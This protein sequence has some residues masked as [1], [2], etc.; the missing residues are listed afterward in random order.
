MKRALLV[1][2]VMWCSVLAPAQTAVPESRGPA[3]IARVGKDFVTEEEFMQRFELLPGFGRH[4]KQHLETAKFELLYSIIAEKLLA[5]QA[6]RWGAAENGAVRGEIDEMTKL[7]SRDE[8]YREEILRNVSV[9][10]SEVKAGVQNATVER[11]LKYIYVEKKSD[12]QFLRSQMKNARDFESLQID[13]SYQAAVDTVT[14]VWGD[15][16]P[17]IEEAAYTLRK[18]EVSPVVAAG[19]G[20]YIFTLVASRTNDFYMN[21][22]SDV[23]KE[24]VTTQLRRRK[25]RERLDS[26][27]AEFLKGKSAYALPRPMQLLSDALRAAY[28]DGDRDSLM[29]LVPSRAD[30]IRKHLGAE[31]TDTIAV[32]GQTVFSIDDIL[33]RLVDRT[34]TVPRERISTVPPRLNT[35]VKTIVQQELLAQEALRRKLDRVP[36]VQRG[37]AMWKSYYLA[38]SVKDSI[39]SSVKVSD[40]EVWAVMKYRDTSVVIPQVQIRELRTK[41]PVEMQSALGEMERGLPFAEAVKKWSS[42]PSAP[43]TGGLTNFF[44]LTDRPVI[45]AAAAAMSIGE[46]FGPIKEN[47]DIVYCELVGKRNAPLEGDTAFAARFAAASKDAIGLK[48]RRKVSLILSRL[49]RQEGVDVYEDRVKAIQVSPIP[50]MTFRILGFGGRI[51]AV[52]FVEPQLDWLDVKPEE[53]ILP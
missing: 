44:T 9:S 28:N 26:F 20:Y 12:A 30:A 43:M 35:E 11:M 14:L 40:A 41:T 3:V 47:R 32:A 23:L 36:D 29:F 15:G 4:R 38:S 31:L 25:E 7:L 8:L 45:G 52:P 2:A 19:D 6:E 34:F 39:R 10:P 16:D 21:M 51:P 1:L 33:T 17:R 22:A 50:M 49:G 18:G 48:G 42:D 37:L 5:Q 53:Q 46:R 27:I 13:S 24:R